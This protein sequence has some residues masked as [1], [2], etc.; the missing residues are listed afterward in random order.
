MTSR[1]SLCVLVVAA[2]SIARAD[3]AP[4]PADPLPAGSTPTVQNFD[5]LIFDPDGNATTENLWYRLIKPD[6]FNPSSATTYPLVIFLH[7]AGGAGYNN[8]AQLMDQTGVL[9]WLSP[10]NRASHPMFMLAPQYGGQANYQ[11]LVVQLIDALRATYP[12]I[13][14][15]RLYI[16]GL[17]QGS[18]NTWGIVASNPSKFAAVI[19]MSAGGDPNV[20]GQTILVNNHNNI[21]YFHCAGD[22]TQATVGGDNTMTGNWD[23]GGRA[24]YTRYGA[25]GHGGWTTMYATPTLLPWVMAQRRGVD[26]PVDPIVPVILS[27]GPAGA[28]SYSGANTI[29]LSGM[30]QV[31]DS[32][33][34]LSDVRWRTQA[35]WQ[36]DSTWPLSYGGAEGA[37]TG[38]SPWS[39]AK[40]TLLSNYNPNRV[41]I[42]ARGTSWGGSTYGGYTYY[43]RTSHVNYTAATAD[44]TAPSAPTNLVLV[45]KTASSVK[46]SWTASTDN[47]AVTQYNIYR[48]GVA[49]GATA[50]TSYTDTGLPGGTAFSYTIK[51]RDAAANLSGESNTLNVATDSG[52]SD[53]TAPSAPT[54]LASTSKTATLVTLGWTA[55]TDNVAVTSYRIYRGGVEVGTST[56]TSFTNTGLTA[57]TTYAF[58]VRAYD[59]AGNQSASSNTVNVTTSAAADTQAPTMPTDMHTSEVTSGTVALAWTASTDNVA[60]VRYRIYRDNVDI[61]TITSTTYTDTACKPE[62]TYIYK[63]RA[64]DAAD[65]NG[66]ATAGLSVTTPPTDGGLEGSVKDGTCSATGGGPIAI[67]CLWALG[68]VRRRR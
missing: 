23:A 16:T 63:V 59:A 33:A 39:T 48:G 60:V 3:P 31:N 50:G 44:S 9:Q 1:V 66:T 10:S 8:T 51:A 11:A 35:P 53:T 65:N 36:N 15:D 40:I 26:S 27:P 29:E 6:G 41:S 61:G 22:N 47:K 45:S 28:V 49:V 54:N 14:A 25:G 42:R 18:I 58:T 68:R 30:V 13:D 64:E 52:P 24:I 19:P 2:A 43:V 34:G 55:S 67:L 20:A 38:T 5:G 62:T 21:W 32:S 46:M 56:T 57:S 4:D 17:S 7:G 37:C 12:N